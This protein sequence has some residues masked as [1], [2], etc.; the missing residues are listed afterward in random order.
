MTENVEDV[1]REMKLLEERGWNEERYKK[2]LEEV[3]ELVTISAEA[4][5]KV[6]DIKLELALASGINSL[7]G[8]V[9]VGAAKKEGIDPRYLMWLVMVMRF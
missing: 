7:M 8:R 1:S 5:A 3:I 9:V 6:R 2:A 4:V